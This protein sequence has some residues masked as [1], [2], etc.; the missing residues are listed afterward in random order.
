VMKDGEIVTM[1][2]YGYAN[3]E[4]EQPIRAVSMSTQRGNHA[5]NRLMNLYCISL[6]GHHFPDFFSVQA[7]QHGRLPNAD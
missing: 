4:T 6:P 3:V 1:Q 5:E 7:D 2:T